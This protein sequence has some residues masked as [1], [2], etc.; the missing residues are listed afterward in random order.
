MLDRDMAK[1][2]AKPSPT[3]NSD[4]AKETLMYVLHVDDDDDFLIIS[5]RLLERQGLF[6]VESVLSV[7]E[8]LKK[9][10]QKQYD[11]IISDYQMFGRSGLDFL[12]ELRNKGN[13]VPF[14]LFTGEYR[15]EIADE[16]LNLGVDRCFDKNGN[17]E[18]VYIEVASAIKE[19]VKA[20][21]VKN[22]KRVIR[23]NGE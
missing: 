10:G 9:L 11:M 8:A 6:Q 4:P 12:K 17:F 18:V 2:S 3:T 14:F 5:K 1:T 7:K 15:K 19:A 23:K 13:D 20:K 21:R 22:A 16:A